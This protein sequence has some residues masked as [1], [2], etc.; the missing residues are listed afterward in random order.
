ML[1]VVAGYVTCLLMVILCG[2]GYEL[3]GFGLILK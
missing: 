1:V 2:F 3:F